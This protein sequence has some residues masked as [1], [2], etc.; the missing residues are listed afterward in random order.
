MADEAISTGEVLSAWED[1]GP[2]RHLRCFA[3]QTEPSPETVRIVAEL[4]LRY[5][6]RNTVDEADHAARVAFLAKDCADIDPVWL[7]LAAAEWARRQ[8]FFPRACEL[9]SS[10]EAIE[11]L[12]APR[13]A[14]PAP[15][16]ANR[17]KI[18][19]PPLTDHEVATLPEWVISMG[20]KMGEIEPERAERLRG[21]PVG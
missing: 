11:R 16:P 1:L 2:A 7:D 5:P 13:N 20:I 8:P 19:P 9:R 3:P 17:P 15:S 10:A 6:P 21:Q 14:L 4:G 12:N 18:V